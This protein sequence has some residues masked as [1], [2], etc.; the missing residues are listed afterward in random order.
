[1]L[2]QKPI[3]YDLFIRF[4]LSEQNNIN[5]GSSLYERKGVMFLNILC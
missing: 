3:C 5:C 4:L 1:M 2:K